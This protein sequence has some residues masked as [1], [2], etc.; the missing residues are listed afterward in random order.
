MEIDVNIGNES[1]TINI[2]NPYRFDVT[3]ITEKIIDFGKRL[4]YDLTELNIERL[5]PK[6]IRGVAGCEA[7]CPADAKGLVRE[8]FGGFKISYIEGGILSAESR[9]KGS[10]KLTLKIFPEFN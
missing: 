5:I 1:L 4:G 3:Q 8:G 9:L 6:M 10:Q 2:G 7:G